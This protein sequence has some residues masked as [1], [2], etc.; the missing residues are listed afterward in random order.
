[1]NQK[2]QFSLRLIQRCPV[3]NQDYNTG[4]FQILDEENNTF[5]AYLTC[6]NCRS[7]IL[8]RVMTLPQGLVGNAILTDLYSE[9][10]LPFSEEQQITSNEVLAIHDYLVRNSDLIE[11]LN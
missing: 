6:S 3:C 10:V 11:K 7:S 9:E 1:M 2:G 5:L 4:K 8:V